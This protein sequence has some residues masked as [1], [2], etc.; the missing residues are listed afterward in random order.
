M[1]WDWLQ[2]FTWWEALIALAAF[3]VIVSNVKWPW[4]SL[5]FGSVVLMFGMGYAAL[6]MN[7]NRDVGWQSV[8]LVIAAI[9]SWDKV[10]VSC[11]K[12][13]VDWKSWGHEIEIDKLS[14][15]QC[16]A[17]YLVLG[18]GAFLGVYVWPIFPIALII[19][20]V[21]TV[22]YSWKTYGQIN[23]A[24]LVG[25]KWR[26]ANNKK[27]AMTKRS[28]TSRPPGRRRKSG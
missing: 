16:M 21:A 1:S 22:L 24:D 19:A 18:G 10:L 6:H 25:P 26:A 8:A 13:I 2:A 11:W 14:W 27:A 12:S 23:F 20:Y 15:K 4:A 3:A 9:A 28:A 5:D 7:V 17:F